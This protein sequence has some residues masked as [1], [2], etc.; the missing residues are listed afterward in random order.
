MSE[1]LGNSEDETGLP[2]GHPVRVYIDENRLQSEYKKVKE[3]IKEKGIVFVGDAIIKGIEIA[4]ELAKAMPERK[5]YFFTRYV[6]E[7]TIENNIVWMPWQKREVDIY[8]YASVVII[9]SIWEEAYGRVSRE[10]YTLD[11]PV[12]VS[13]IGGLPESVDEKEE[14]I[15]N[16]YKNIDSWREKIENII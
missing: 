9:P 5:F 3:E 12:L 1:F 14:F 2:D 4:K 7:A 10:A 13:N 15:V 16:D 6:Q 11:I 8:K